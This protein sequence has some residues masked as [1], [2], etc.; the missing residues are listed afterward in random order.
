MP[1]SF[2]R[3][4]CSSPGSSVHGISQARILEWVAI[5]F[6]RD[7][8]DPGIVLASL[9]L[10]L[11]ADSLPGA[12]WEAQYVCVC[13][14]TYVFNLIYNGNLPNHKGPRGAVSNLFGTRDQFHERQFFHELEVGDASRMIQV[15]YIY[16]A[17]YYYFICS[18]LGH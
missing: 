10:L 18:T 15:H 17:L 4:D 13:L 16:C 11:Q 3:M 6:S 8:P 7:L 14:C 9:G 5:P 12:A 2:D 1:D